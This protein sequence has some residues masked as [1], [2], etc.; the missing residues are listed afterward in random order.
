MSAARSSHP[1]DAR[2]RQYALGLLGS[3][4]RAQVEAHLSV[5]LHCRMAVNE[6]RAD[7]VTAV[8]GLPAPGPLPPLRLV[9]LAV[10][11]PTI[12]ARPPRVG[13]PLVAVLTLL[14]LAGLGWGL[15][16][17]AQ[18][19]AL[20]AQ[21]RLVSGWL[22]RPDVS[23]LTLTDLKKQPSGQVLLSKSG[24]VLFVLPDPPAG[25]EYRA[26]VAHD[27][28]LGQPMTLAVQ[29]RSGVFVLD[30]GQND[31]LCLSLERP[32]TP[33]SGPTPQRILGKAFL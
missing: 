16:Q 30:L 21:Q 15:R 26:W 27:W 9:D 14:A 2:L 1:D 18:Q 24:R 5:C 32:E 6:T 33:R 25:M 19:Q 3:A 31:Y 28:H 4:G 23:A 29:S 17:T 13:W 7:L 8:E 22:A 11:A 20:A 12:P 10:T